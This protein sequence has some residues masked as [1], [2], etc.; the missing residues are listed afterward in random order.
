MEPGRPQALRRAHHLAG[1]ARGVELHEVD[2][3]Q[4]ALELQARS[5]KLRDRLAPPA[6]LPAG[7]LEHSQQP[8]DP[9]LLAPQPRLTHPR[10]GALE[11]ALRTLEITEIGLGAREVDLGHQLD[12]GVV[13]LLRGSDHGV[14]ACKGSVHQPGCELALGQVELGLQSERI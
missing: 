11:P 12:P 4:V 8:E 9:H 13:A 14:P 1:V 5:G 10:Q 7:R 6:A 2:H 3:Q